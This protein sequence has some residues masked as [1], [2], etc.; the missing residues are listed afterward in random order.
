MTRYKIVVKTRGFT[1]FVTKR[2]REFE[3]LHKIVKQK[4]NLNFSQ[5]PSKVNL[6]K[7]QEA[8]FRDR[9]IALEK[10]LNFVQSHVYKNLGSVYMQEYYEFIEIGN[11]KT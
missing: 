6:L 9:K 1:Y 3:E 2:F 4:Y 11:F 5:F 8:V 10:F 7:S